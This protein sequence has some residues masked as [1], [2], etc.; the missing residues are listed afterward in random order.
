MA[1]F[2]A[3]KAP[4]SNMKADVLHI[5]LCLGITIA[6]AL[7]EMDWERG[8]FTQVNTRHCIGAGQEFI[9]DWL[10]VFVSSRLLGTLVS[11]KASSAPYNKQVHKYDATRPLCA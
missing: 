3:A 8:N 9:F 1:D 5:I 2:K 4:I 11:C 6:C 10:C 7:L